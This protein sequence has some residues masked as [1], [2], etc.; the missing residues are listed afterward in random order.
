MQASVQT[1][2]TAT[3]KRSYTVAEIIDILG[4]GKTSAYKLVHSGKFK[5]VNVG[6]ALRI[7]KRSFDKWFDERDECDEDYDMFL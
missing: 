5:V 4:I 6:S 3:D 7:S 2:A 1:C